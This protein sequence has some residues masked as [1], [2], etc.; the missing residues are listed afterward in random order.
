MNMMDRVAM[1]FGTVSAVLFAVGCG[2]AE[3]VSSPTSRIKAAAGLPPVAYLAKRVG[4]DAV[5]VSSVLPEGR[6]PHDFSPGPREVSG[7]AAAQVFLTTG[8]RFETALTRMLSRERKVV[9]VSRGV[10]RIP[11][12][13]SCGH[14][15]HDG[16]H[17]HHHDHSGAH[18]DGGHDEEAL[19]PHIWLDAENACRMAE[20]IRDAFSELDPGHAG[21][22]AANCAEVSADLRAR[23]AKLKADLQPYRGRSF[24]VYH[25]A[26]GYFGAM[27]GLR[28][29][30]VE[31]GGREVTP[32][33]LA[34]VIRKAR[35]DK[36]KVI[37]TQPQFSPASCRALERELGVRTVPADPLRADLAENFDYLG[38]ALK[39]GFAASS[40][41]EL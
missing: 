15:H 38:G 4:G 36:V 9:D 32:A 29:E 40:G 39:Q 5:E 18:R 37:F 17:G 28:Q 27:L 8:M 12:L 2:D 25:P 11:M 31:L 13:V 35:R 30:A 20:N 1:L 41:G 21:V 6:S 33:R 23:A 19:D 34:E 24:Y 10:R 26:F 7:A 14:D 3:S 22:Y 16:D